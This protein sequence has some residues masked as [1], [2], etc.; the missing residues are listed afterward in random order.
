MTPQKALTHEKSLEHLSEEFVDE[1][2]AVSLMIS[3]GKV[4][5]NRNWVSQDDSSVPALNSG[6]CSMKRLGVFL[7]PL[8]GWD[9]SPSQVTSQ[10]FVRLSPS[11]LL[12][13]IYTPG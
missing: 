5:P 13:P 6:F 9:T 1:K 10:Q 12:V 11:N 2:D 8:D 7:L 3:I 4:C